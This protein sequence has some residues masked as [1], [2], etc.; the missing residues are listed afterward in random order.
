MSND[1]RELSWSQMTRTLSHY[2]YTLEVWWY[3]QGLGLQEMW[4]QYGTREKRRM[5][6]AV[7]QLG[8]SLAKTVIKTHILTG[9]DCMSKVGSKHAA[10]ACDP[11]NYMTNFRETDKLLEQYSK[12]AYKYLIRVWAG[13]RST[14]TCETFDQF[15]AESYLT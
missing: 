7:S 6:Q 9:D 8:P 12:L 5:G 10:M 14:T 11:V 4:Q 3:F 15:R 2:C 1:A 13:A